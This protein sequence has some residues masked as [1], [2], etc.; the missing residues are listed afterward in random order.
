MCMC[1]IKNWY[2]DNVK[3]YYVFATTTMYLLENQRNI[4]LRPN[5]LKQRD[6]WVDWYP[7]QRNKQ[8]VKKEN[9]VNE[10]K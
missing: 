3:D 2:I 5:S 9:N 10:M 6:A 1:D 8:I 4:L 7:A